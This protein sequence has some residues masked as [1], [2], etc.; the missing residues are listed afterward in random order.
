MGGLLARSYIESTYYNNDV[1]KLVFIATPHLGAPAAYLMWEGGSIGNDAY[2]VIKSLIIGFEAYKNG[3][4]N[5]FS[6]VRDDI[7]SVRDLLPIYDYIKESDSGDFRTYPENYPR[8]HF[9]ELLNQESNMQNLEAVDVLNI[10][11]D[12]NKKDTLDY[13]VVEDKY[14]DD[15]RWEHGYPINYDGLLGIKGLVNGSGDG[16]VPQR[17]NNGLFENELT[18]NSNH[19]KIVSDSQ[20]E[21]INFLSGNLPLNDISNNIFEKWFMVRIYSPANFLIKDP[22]GNRVGMDAEGNEISEIN[23]SFYFNEDGMQFALIPNPG[24]GDYKVELLGTADGDY[25]LNL[26]Y[27]DEESIVQ[28][29]FMGNIIEDQQQEFLFDFNPSEEEEN[30][31]TDLMPEDVTA[32]VIQIVKPNS[33]EKFFRSQILSLEY[34]VYDDYSSNVMP[35]ITLNGENVTSSTIDLSFYSVG[36]YELRLTATDSAGNSSVETVE[37]EIIANIKTSIKDIENFYESGLLTKEAKNKLLPPLKQLERDFELFKGS[38]SNTENKLNTLDIHLKNLK[39][40]GK[41]DDL[42]YDIIK[43]NIDYLRINLLYE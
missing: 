31:L 13:M 32:P 42:V 4:N 5:V 22:Q 37:L 34:Q 6:Y 33:G 7:S 43:A 35:S 14:F 30:F 41:L 21:I 9:L 40:Q 11:A 20:K 27:V 29:N 23:K 28:R 16:T 12:N 8:N 36:T 1:D 19:T 38:K 2:D 18:F 39:K 24:E 3:H 17:S 10:V 25:K 15:G 26:A